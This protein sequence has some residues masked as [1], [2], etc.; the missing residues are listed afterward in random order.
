[1]NRT[2]WMAVLVLAA[3]ACG[4][5]EADPPQGAPPSAAQNGGMA[6]DTAAQDMTGEGTRAGQ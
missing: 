4:P 6:A 2:W 3:G 5:G 1:M